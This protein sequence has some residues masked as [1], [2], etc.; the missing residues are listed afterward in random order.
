MLTITIVYTYISLY[1]HEDP[2]IQT[3]IR[4]IQF[5]GK[6]KY[7]EVIIF[8][9]KNKINTSCIYGIRKMKKDLRF[10]AGRQKNIFTVLTISVRGLVLWSNWTT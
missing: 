8:G 4:I 10:G 2:P 6:T 9:K 5:R 3:E 1:P 7:G